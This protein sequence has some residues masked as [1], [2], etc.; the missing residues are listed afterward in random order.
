M[1]LTISETDAPRKENGRS[2][3][4][5]FCHHQLTVQH[6]LVQLHQCKSKGCQLKRQHPLAFFFFPQRDKS[7]IKS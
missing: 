5:G 4:P 1:L 3:V 6:C 2:D 7:K